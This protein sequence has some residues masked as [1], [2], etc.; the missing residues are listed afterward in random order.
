MLAAEVDLEWKSLRLGP[1]E[2]DLQIQVTYATDT[3]AQVPTSGGATIAASSP[4]STE[5]VVSNTHGGGAVK[6]V[7]VNLELSPLF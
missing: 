3:R 5:R 4:P 7:S 2:Y 1:G 6:S